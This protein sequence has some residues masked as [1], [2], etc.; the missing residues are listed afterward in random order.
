MKKTILCS[1]CKTEGYHQTGSKNCRRLTF[2]NNFS[3]LVSRDT[4]FSMIG[5]IQNE[6]R[7]TPLNN[8][9]NELMSQLPSF[10]LN[11]AHRIL[12]FIKYFQN[13]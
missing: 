1:F 10:Q 9:G 8:R 2:Q 5:K 12:S 4:K 3:G 11:K 6:T 7:I 13:H